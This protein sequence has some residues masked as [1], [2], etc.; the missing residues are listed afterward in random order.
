MKIGQLLAEIWAKTWNLTQI[1]SGKTRGCLYWGRCL[2]WRIYGIYT[3]YPGS[4]SHHL[5][6]T[7][8]FWSPLNHHSK[9]LRIPAIHDVRPDM[10]HFKSKAR[11]LIMSMACNVILIWL[12]K[13]QNPQNVTFL[14][15]SGPSIAGI[16]N[17]EAMGI[18]Y[19]KLDTIWVHFALSLPPNHLNP[20]PVVK[21][22]TP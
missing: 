19:P 13:C 15:I 17:L 18:Q 10:T 8:G 2:Y 12:H 5:L 3:R 14:L 22:I 16:L 20:H 21:K 7:S 9:T 6:T 11:P 1:G 4:Y